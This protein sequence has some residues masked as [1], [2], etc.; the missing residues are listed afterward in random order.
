MGCSELLV[1]WNIHTRI[2]LPYRGIHSTT[3]HFSRDEVAT[4]LLPTIPGYWFAIK[5][6]CANI[7]MMSQIMVMH[8]KGRL[9]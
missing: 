8:Y 2:I 1:C 3:F 7:I 6:K 4:E 9:M 5:E